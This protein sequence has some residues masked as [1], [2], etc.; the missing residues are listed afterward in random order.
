M[1]RIDDK[2]TKPMKYKKIWKNTLKWEISKIS[3]LFKNFSKYK[4]TNLNK[5]YKSIEYWEILHS[6]LKFF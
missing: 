2:K 1:A 3:I 5:I 4:F 6:F